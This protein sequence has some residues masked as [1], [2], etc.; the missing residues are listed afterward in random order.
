MKAENLT[1]LSL[2]DGMSCMRI[3]LDK[4]GITPG[5]Y[6]ASE[7]D[8]HANKE[9]ATNWPDTI[10]LG[11][12]T[13][14]R[15]WDIDWLKV[16]LLVGGSPCQGF[17]FAGKQAGTKANLNGVD[18]IIETREQYLQAKADGATFYSQSHLF[19]EYVLCLDYAKEQNPNIKFMLENVKM[20]KCFMDM[21]TCALGVEPVFINSALVSAQNRQRFY[22]CNWEVAQPEDRG[23]TWGDIREHG[24]NEYY[25]TEKALQWLAIHSQ[26]KNKTLDIWSDEEKAQMVEANHYKNYSSQRFFGICD[27]PSDQSVVAAMRG[28]YIVDG[29]RQD[30]KQKTS[31]LTKQFIEFRFDGKTNSLTTVSKD[32]VVVPF[33]LPE[34]IPA[35][36]FFFRYITVVECCR[37]QGVPDDYFKVS[38]NTQAYKMLGNGW[39]CDTIEH[40]FNCLFKSA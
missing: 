32:N 25:Y 17:S 28:R 14:W 5:K 40:I 21:I 37:L 23:I 36:M 8:Q 20:K 38:S 22:W 2:F 4:M 31:G 13:K 35:E 27:L 7:I 6:Y 15:E 19:W 11:D 10:Q 18:F 30:S 26:R 16:D 24:V 12:V 33:T 3:T 29:V 1:V 9:V 39:Q 34:R